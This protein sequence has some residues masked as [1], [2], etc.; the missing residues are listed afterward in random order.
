M[1]VSQLMV[2]MLF[3]LCGS[4][5][6]TLMAQGGNIKNDQFWKTK[7]GQPINSQG[8]GIFRFP[9]SA[10]GK[11]KYYWYGVH[12]TGADQYRNDPSVTMKNA[13]FESVTCYSSN[14]LVN[15]TFE[16]GVLAKEEI[17]KSDGKL[18][19]V[20]RLGVAYIKELKVYAM[21]VQHN[22]AVLIA[23]AQSPTGPFSVHQQLDMT[24]TIG[25]PNTGDQTVFTDEDSG[26]SYLVYCYG[27]GRNKI[28]ISEIGVKDDKVN[29]LDCTKIFEGAGREGNCMFKYKGKYYVCASDLY[30]WDA[31]NVYY[32]IADDIRGPYIPVNNMQIMNGSAEDYGHVTQ[33]GFFVT[34]KG[35]KQE[36]VIY[37]G[38][39]WA[40]FAGN[41]L[42]Y[43]QWF[44]LSFVDTL[45]Y[46]NS[47]HSWNLNERS[48]EW[49][50]NTDNNWV[51]NGSFEADRKTMPSLV[52]PVQQYLTGWTTEIVKGRPITLDSTSTLLNH[53]NNT[54]DRKI[55]IG[56]RS[57][58]LSDQN[59][60]GRKVFQTITSTT[61]VK[62]PDGSYTLSAMVKNSSGFT[63]LMMYAGSG[64]NAKTFDINSEHSSWASIRI[65]HVTVKGGKIEIG[66]LAE[67]KGGAFCYVDDVTFI[68]N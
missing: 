42:G 12:Y 61:F 29:L 5:Q 49:W 35:N 9:D 48:G 55:V 62:L 40:D 68:K 17:I 31:S 6:M 16:K 11:L 1:K 43:N 32:L 52:K 54:G 67:G 50:V 46:F 66:F 47:L 37:C 23:L 4:C 22:N 7:D 57:L 19:W 8:G 56:E 26:K 41:G 39:R 30:G 63:K 27:R 2:I 58:N 18:G 53:E 14:D 10:T 13:D 64:K 65:E 3:V 28:Y 33:T 25:T 59:D 24:A 34:V 44:P 36:T 38:D 51:R 45:P 21:F 15:W 20:G 60:F